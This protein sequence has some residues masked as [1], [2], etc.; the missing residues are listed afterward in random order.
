MARKK[1]EQYQDFDTDDFDDY[2]LD[3]DDMDIRNLSKDFYSTE[4][5]DPFQTQERFS[6][7]RKIER[8]KEIKDLY[9]QFDEWDDYDSR[10]DW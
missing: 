4:W 1:Q 5:E 6:T 7:R 9:S 10:N 2:A 8:R 3:S